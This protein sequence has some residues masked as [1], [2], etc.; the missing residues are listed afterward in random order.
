MTLINTE[1]Y[2]VTI[3]LLAVWVNCKSVPFRTKITTPATFIREY[4]L[5][6]SVQLC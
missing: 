4:H 3:F 6:T 2:R 5:H 1:I